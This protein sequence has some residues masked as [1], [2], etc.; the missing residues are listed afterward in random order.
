MTSLQKRVVT[1]CVAGPIVLGLIYLGGI[2]FLIGVLV[3]GLVAQFEFYKLVDVPISWA[4]VGLLGGFLGLAAIYTSNFAPLAAAFSL[5]LAALPFLI[6]EKKSV[7]N[8]GLC[9]TGIVY[10]CL[11]FGAMI[12]IRLG[13]VGSWSSDEALVVTLLLLC[14]VWID[15]I[16]SYFA[17]RAF[18][19][20]PLA[21]SISPNKTVEGFIG[22]SLAVALAAAAA[23][24]SI[25]SFIRPEVLTG[26]AIIVI[27]FGP[28]GDLAESALKRDLGA[29]DSGSILP[30][31]GGLMD[32][33]DSLL[34]VFP[35]AYVF[36][37][38]V[39]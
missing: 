33:I 31:H 14:L 21:P 38:L 24:Y 25:G 28:I 5:P 22:G 36:L 35:I 13:L 34:L 15:D 7:R 1:A 12:P 29:K 19:K 23:G 20:K 16:F 9:V 6:D 26:I 17:G 4:V 10:P 11:L 8:F 27:A 37:K 3:F 32:R 2:P 18:G 30:G 39:L